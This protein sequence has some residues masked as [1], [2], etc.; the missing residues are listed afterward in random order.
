MIRNS[1]WIAVLVCVCVRKQR[2]CRCVGVCGHSE[3]N[4]DWI[5]VLM[6]VCVRENSDWIAVLVCVQCVLHVHCVLHAAIFSAT[7]SIVCGNEERAAECGMASQ[8]PGRSQ[9]AS[10]STR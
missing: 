9:N 3:K 7:R 5:A 2:W 8:S 6:C 1:D 10:N 4:S